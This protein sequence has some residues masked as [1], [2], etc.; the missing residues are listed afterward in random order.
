[1]GGRG[2]LNLDLTPAMF[3]TIEV[4][5]YQITSDADPV[6]DRRL[7]YV[8][9]ADDLK[10]E[11]SAE[12][13]SY[14]PGEEACINFR[15]TDHAGRPVSAALGVE[16]VDEAVF[17]LSDKQPG[18][19]KVFMYLQKELLTPRYEVHQF[20]FEKVV[21]DDFRDEKP[22]EAAAQRERAAQVLLAA[23]GTVRDKDVKAEYGRESIQ[24][25]RAEYLPVY[26]KRVFEKAQAIAGAMAGYY[27]S[28]PASAEGFNRDLELFASSGEAQRKILQDPWGNRLIG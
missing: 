7:I 16:I 25:K 5:A 14:K 23:A 8:D 1:T 24:A 2:N 13:D 26:M 27:Q 9:P 20:S 15:A 10:V 12:R 28:H 17:A 3:G 4:R 6:S 11:V 18:F 21:L 19:E 22:V